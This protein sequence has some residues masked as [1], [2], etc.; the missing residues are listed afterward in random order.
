MER[1]S[2]KGALLLAFSEG[3]DE[4]EELSPLGYEITAELGRGGMAVIY[5]ARQIT[6]ERE[7]A[8]KVMLPKYAGDDAM[9]ERFQVEVKAMAALEN[10]HILP[11][12]EVGEWNG[13]PFFSM[14]LAEGGCL[15][16]VLKSTTPDFRKVVG[17]MQDVAGAIHFAH[18]RGVLHRDL[19]PGNFLFDDKGHIYVGDFGV[20]KLM[21]ATGDI[22]LT[23]TEFIVG[24]PHYMAPEVASGQAPVASVAGGVYSLGAVFYEC[25]SGEKPY[26]SFTNMASLLRAVVDE[27]IPP[28]RSVRSNLPSDI[29]V[30]CSKALA[31]NPS[32]RYS[33][34]EDFQH[35]LISWEAGKPIA[36]R[37]LS[38]YEVLLRWCKRRP[39]SL[40]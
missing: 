25:L 21:L 18:Q 17:W 8:L 3:F 13:M 2:K 29:E 12:Y 33:S 30:I 40:G 20:A 26:S 6:P 28:V 16:S 39:G 9:R 36:A 35:D 4:A 24:T 32:D 7:V 11:I 34:V 37:R 5:H 10:N 14:K 23:K 38:F 19:K 15:A 27:E 22:E 1:E 31:K